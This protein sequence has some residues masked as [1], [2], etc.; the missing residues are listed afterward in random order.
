MQSR[1]SIFANC[2]CGEFLFCFTGFAAVFC[3][4]WVSP[5]SFCENKTKSILLLS[6][7]VFV[8]FIWIQRQQH[9]MRISIHEVMQFAYSTLFYSCCSV[10]LRSLYKSSMHWMH[11]LFGYSI[12][13]EFF[14]CELH[15]QLRNT[16]H[17]WTPSDKRTTLIKWLMKWIAPLMPIGFMCDDCGKCMSKRWFRETACERKVVHWNI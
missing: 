2:A 12:S 8:V 7:S 15:S 5:M 6:I 17:K 14:T 11:R 9:S 10:Y 4:A 16:T 1:F 13:A 3:A